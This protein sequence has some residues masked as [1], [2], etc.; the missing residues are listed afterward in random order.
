VFTAT[1]ERRIIF[2]GRA[3]IIGPHGETLLADSNQPLFHVE[4]GVR[5]T[6][7]EPIN[8]W[9]IIVLTESADPRYAAAFAQATATGGL[10]GFLEIY[11]ARDLR[12]TLQR[13]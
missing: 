11:L 12:V 13:R 9:R 3:R 1:A 6:D 2:L 10:P 7:D 8:T 5:V 4:H